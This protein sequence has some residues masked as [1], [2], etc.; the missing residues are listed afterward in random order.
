[1][2][3]LNRGKK[4]FVGSMFDSIAFRYD[5]L[6]HF[7][8]FGID[9]LWRKKAIKI[10]SRTHRNPDI[11]DVATGTGDLAIA[12]MEIDPVHVTGID[13]SEKML[14]IGIEKIRKKELSDRIE[15]LRGDSEKIPFP[16]ERFD[17]VMVAFGVRN[18]SDPLMGLS[19]MNRVL[20]HGGLIMVL[21]FSKPAK[22]PFRQIYS[23]YFLNILPVIGRVFSK[24]KKAYRYLPESVMQFPDNEQ[25]IELLI[26]AGF[27]SAI[28]KKLTF[29]VASIYTAL[30]S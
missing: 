16:D 28:Q 15:L 26:K 9:R 3:D 10:I 6:N 7:M 4:A 19:E 20:R 29:G 21:E 13:I 17:V 25:F 8:S 22:F 30:K 18:F 12:A 27:S 5:F 2:E 14:E 11:L 23:F 24:N 1:M